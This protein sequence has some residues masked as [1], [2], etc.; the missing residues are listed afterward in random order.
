MKTQIAKLIGISLNDYEGLI[1]SSY[2]HWCAIFSRD[3]LQYQNFMNDQKIFLWFQ[4]QIEIYEADFVAGIKIYDN[5]KGN[6][7][8]Y[9]NA[10]IAKV[11]KHWPQAL[12]VKPQIS[13]KLLINT[14]LN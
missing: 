11:F 7:L 5:P 12:G 3:G 1:F 6:N 4:T 10:C 14:K 8:D 13:I 9:Y 2:N